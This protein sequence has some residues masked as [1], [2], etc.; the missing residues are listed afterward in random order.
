MIIFDKREYMK[1]N[2]DI[3]TAMTSANLF[4]G[5]LVT[6]LLGLINFKGV[7]EIDILSYVIVTSLILFLEVPDNDK[8]SSK[9][10][11]NRN[12]LISGFDKGMFL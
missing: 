12:V 3:S 9:N 6:V 8:F 2:A 4:S 7:F 10:K 5:V 11:E 1:I